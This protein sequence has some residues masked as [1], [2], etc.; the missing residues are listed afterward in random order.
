VVNAL[1]EELD[2]NIFRDGNE[3]EIQFKDGNP[4]KPLKKLG[5]SKKMEQR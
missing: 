1:S 3:Y 5:K 2:L 4:V